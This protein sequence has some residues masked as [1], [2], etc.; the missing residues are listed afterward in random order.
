MLTIGKVNLWRAAVRNETI[1][2]FLAGRAMS[3]IVW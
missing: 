1:H 3:R 2:A